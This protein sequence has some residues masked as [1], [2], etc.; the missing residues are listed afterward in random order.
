MHFATTGS[1]VA[2]AVAYAEAGNIALGLSELL[3][4]E[5]RT[6]SFQ[7]WWVA[8]GHLHALAKQNSEARDALAIAIGLTSDISIRL[9]L[10]RRR[11][12]LE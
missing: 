5:S 1:L 3:A 10:E 4:I 2:G 6:K 11:K 8:K 7:P 9:H 12:S